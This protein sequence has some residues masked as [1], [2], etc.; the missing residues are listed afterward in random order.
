VFGEAEGFNTWAIFSI[1]D[2][3]GEFHIQSDWGNYQHRW[4]IAHLGDAHTKHPMP[5]THFLA[6]RADGSYVTDKLHYGRDDREVYSPELTQQ[7]I[8]ERI[9]DYRKGGHLTADEAR[10]AMDELD[11]VDF[12]TPDSFMYSSGDQPTLIKQIGVDF[13]D[14]MYEPSFG[15]V[16]LRYKLLPFFFEYLR[17]E[18]LKEDQNEEGA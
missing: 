7:V 6:M 16:L 15:Y 3:T 13:E 11:L 5:L 14:I 9:V 12:D 4:N 10:A 18:V 17:R 8:K 1:N 2:V